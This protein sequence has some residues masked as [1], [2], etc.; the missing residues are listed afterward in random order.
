LVFAIPHQIPHLYSFSLFNLLRIE[1][2]P[3]E[4]PPILDGQEDDIARI[5]VPL[6]NPAY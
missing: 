3:L 1:Q 4:I 5:R 6:I 2:V